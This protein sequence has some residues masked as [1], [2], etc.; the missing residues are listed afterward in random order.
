MVCVDDLDLIN[1]S[2]QQVMRNFIDKY[3][4]NVNFVCTCSNIKKVIEPMYSRLIS[5]PLCLYTDQ[6]ISQLFDNICALERLVILPDAKNFLIRNANRSIRSLLSIIEKCKL[7]NQQITYDIANQLC[8]NIAY[9]LFDIFLK[10]IYANHLYEASTILLDIYKLGYSV[11]D[12]YDEMLIYI[13]LSSLSEKI[14]YI[15]IQILTKH[16]SIFYDGQEHQLQLITFTNTLI[17]S[18]VKV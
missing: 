16:I 10:H 2:N 11:I 12:I 18:I 8:T 4:L 17:K 9:G 14:K 5:I 15:I 13:K 6:Q 7:Y 1:E 3:R